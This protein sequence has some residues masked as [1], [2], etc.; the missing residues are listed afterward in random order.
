MEISRG[1]PGKSRGYGNFDAVPAPP[2]SV[3]IPQYTPKP[4]PSAA[5]RF[6]IAV[7]MVPP[8]ADGSNLDGSWSTVSWTSSR[9][10]TDT[11]AWGFLN[12][13]HSIVQL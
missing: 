1:G 4:R 9:T 6:Q 3:P 5:D 11:I 2:G 7:W 8:Y 10:F 13:G 12:N